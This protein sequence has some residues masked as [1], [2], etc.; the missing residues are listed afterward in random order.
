MKFIFLFPVNGGT[1][2]ECC[3]NLAQFGGDED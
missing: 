3:V 1:V 2:V